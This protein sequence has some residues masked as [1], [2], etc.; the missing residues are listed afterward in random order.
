[1]E[2]AQKEKWIKIAQIGLLLLVSIDLYT[3]F[4]S[5]RAPKLP[6]PVVM[7]AK[8]Q[9]L[10]I[11][12]YITQT[13]N[14][15]SF[16]S[17][18]LV[19][20]VEGYL[21]AIHFVDGTFVKKGKN[22][23]II[24]Q[25]PYL[26]KLREA[27][28]SVTAQKAIQ[29]YDKTEYERQKRMFKENATSLNTVQK[30]FAKSQESEAEVA[31]AVANEAI[32]AIN[33]SYTEVN[34]PFDGRIGR[35]MIDVG[36]LVGNGVATILATLNQLDPIYIY[37][38]L[39]EIDFIKL[40][41]VARASGASEKVIKQIPVQVGLQN[42]SGYKYE[43]KLDFVNTGLNASTGTMQFRALL[44]NK[45]Y[46]L[47]PGLFVQ[48][49]VAIS[50]PAPQLTIPDTAVQYDQIGSYVLIVDQQNKVNLQRVV[51]GGLEKGRRAILQGIKPEE[52]I[53]VGGL[54]NATP[55][56]LVAPQT[57]KIA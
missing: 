11:T 15:V 56:N 52:Q 49:R 36:N 18:D 37:F 17:V 51:L 45:D 57:E 34:A 9:R 8:P 39:N 24:E 33:Y 54:Q 5:N 13:G 48:I 46:S 42:E 28:A 10:P 7:V 2:Q 50:D 30:W 38:N 32:A 27:R 35:H 1:M 47:L 14:I 44:P 31:K 43:G 16:N 4:I 26:E 29:T 20:R 53:I 23:F 3:R 22:L 55:G 6:T 41:A 40:R 12:E 25:E 21:D 19:A